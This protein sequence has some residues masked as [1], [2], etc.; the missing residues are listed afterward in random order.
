MISSAALTINI[1]ILY[2]LMGPWCGFSMQGFFCGEIY[3][4]KGP[5]HEIFSG[6][7]FSFYSE[8]NFF[9]GLLK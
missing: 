5:S 3:V 2:V 8:T 1:G 9:P 7:L 6:M 4:T